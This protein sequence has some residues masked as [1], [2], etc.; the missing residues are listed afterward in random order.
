MTFTQLFA[1]SL[2]RG[3]RTGAVLALTTS[4]A[5]LTLSKGETDS[6]WSAVNAV[7]HIVDGD[8]KTQPKAFSPRESLLGLGINA[9]AMGAWG[10]L[11]EG[12][13]L[14]V[15]RRPSLLFG[16]LGAL[17]TAVIDYKI[18]PKRLTPGIETVLS[19]R[20]I[21]VSYAVLAATLAAAGRWNAREE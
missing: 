13:L 17:C 19:P 4:A 20:A 5:I 15:C 2:T 9:A 10:I 1:Q 8:E 6:A 12:G 16:A 11:Y 18:V 14:V 7:A 3:L 21:V